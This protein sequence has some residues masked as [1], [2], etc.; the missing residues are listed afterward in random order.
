LFYYQTAIS[1]NP[2][3]TYFTYS[4]EQ[5]LSSG[6]RVIVNFGRKTRQLAYI[7]NRINKEDCPD[8][9]DIKEIDEII[10]YS[11]LI[12]ED[13]F[14]ILT[15]TS[16][17]YL[18]S[19]GKVFDLVFKT[20]GNSPLDT[21]SKNDSSQNTIKRYNTKLTKSSLRKKRFVVNASLKNL[22]NTKITQQGMDII[23]YLLFYPDADLQE[24]IHSL[25][26][27]TITPI[28]TLIK[29]N[30]LSV[31]NYQERNGSLSDPRKVN[32]S[33]AQKMIVEDFFK[34]SN[35]GTLKHLLYGITGSGKTEVY[36]EIME[37]ILSQGQQIL[38]MLPE[39]SLTPQIIK[40]TKARFPGKNI[41]VYHSNLTKTLRRKVFSQ[42]VHSDIDILLGTRSSIWVPLK[43]LGFIVV[44][45]EHD[46]SFMQSENKPVYDARKVVS[47]LSE[48]KGIPVI[49]GSATP[50]IE[51][52]YEAST[53][54]IHLHTLKFRPKGLKLPD[55]SNVNLSKIP[56][57]K[58]FLTNDVLKGIEETIKKDAQCM[59][60]TGKKGFASYVTCG[61]CG[62]TIKC[63]NC[64]V[65]LTYHKGD[66]DLRCHYCGYSQPFIYQCPSC[67]NNSLV[68]R[69]FG[70]ERVE[71]QLQKLFPDLRI[72]RIDRD[73]APNTQE[74]EKA[75][76][77]I[78]RRE[79]DIVV[80]TRMISKG[81]DFPDVQLVVIL[82]ADHMLY[83]PDFRSTERTFS[84]IHQ[85]S[86]RA[87][88]ARK[89]AKVIIQ[90]YSPEEDPIRF[91]ERNDY[92]S[93]YNSEIQKRHQAEYPPFKRIILLESKDTDSDKAF[94]RLEKLKERLNE[95]N[96][97]ALYQILGPVEAFLK[98]LSGKY[99]YHMLLKID[100]D[101]DII[102]KVKTIL[103]QNDKYL[104]E[105]SIIIDPIRTII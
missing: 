11:A 22:S 32:L 6:S 14:N 54:K 4:S 27:K 30:V 85:M 101:N 5:E 104:S 97:T 18:S 44:D 21:F 25:D 33:T 58:G 102:K 28:Q 70:S 66:G 86:G 68:P 77:I 47:K 81:L 40:R 93:F 88:R 39:I 45:E 71:E 53:E 23:Q 8:G 61:V 31:E 92:E 95:Q 76:K 103:K 72:I 19:P 91:A 17:F 9:I 84:L 36:F 89:E 16:D 63:P 73:I 48:L 7:I 98:K 57:I 35:E 41:A 34:A 51:S 38:F 96:D 105:I 65:S 74:L 2:L 56:V 1:N 94:E 10:D 75:W 80:G 64:D 55:I 87:G 46:E 99:R 79:V 78:E 43:R 12:D 69:G 67:S 15:W 37:K 50:S 83:F 24:I 13:Y 52:Y 60:L 62:Y 20:L 42:A 26:M 90:S 3:R 100:N 49:F 59:I 29:N 82:N